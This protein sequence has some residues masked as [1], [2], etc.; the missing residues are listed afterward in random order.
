LARRASA[1]APGTGPAGARGGAASRRRR[2]GRGRLLRSGG[3]AGGGGAAEIA[4][5]EIA[6]AGIP[7]DALRS[8]RR[9]RRRQLQ[10]DTVRILER[11]HIDAERGQPGDLAVP[12]PA[13]VEEPD[14]LLQVVVAG[15]AEAEMVQAHPVRVESVT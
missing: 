3:P 2:A 5:A 7:P 6:A 9:Y 14:R 8:A 10:L 13:G 1:P 12:H 11:E 15:D 4:A